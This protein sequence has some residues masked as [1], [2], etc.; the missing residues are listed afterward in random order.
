MERYIAVCYEEHVSDRAAGEEITANELC[1]EIQAALLV[2][3]GHDYADWNEE[4]GADG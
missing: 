3:Y 4:E 1:N 2:G